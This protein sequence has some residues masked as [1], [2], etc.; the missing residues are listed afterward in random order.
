MPDTLASCGNTSRSYNI[1]NTHQITH[2]QA[3]AMTT[4]S[5]YQLRFT[6][7]VKDEVTHIENLVRQKQRKMT[8][9]Q[10]EAEFRDW[11]PD[12]GFS[13][14]RYTKIFKLTELYWLIKSFIAQVVEDTGQQQQAILSQTGFNG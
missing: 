12:T 11:V 5:N 13:C 4:A 14:S 9:D 1:I 7:L 8:N 2:T 10:V 6:N 3:D